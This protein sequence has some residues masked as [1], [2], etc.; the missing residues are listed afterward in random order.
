[1]PKRFF[2]DNSLACSGKFFTIP[3]VKAS[4]KKST[5]LATNT[6]SRSEVT[7]KTCE[8][9]IM[10]L[11]K[12][13]FRMIL[14]AATDLDLRP[15]IREAFVQCCARHRVKSKP[16]RQFPRDRQEYRR[17]S[18]GLDNRRR[19]RKPKF[20]TASPLPLQLETWKDSRGNRYLLS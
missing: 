14:A 3:C 15:Y 7:S 1:M 4:Q 9:H 20:K 8:L 2:F 13:A 18:R 19:G 6:N 10:A 11:G 12:G 17:K 5:L 16:G